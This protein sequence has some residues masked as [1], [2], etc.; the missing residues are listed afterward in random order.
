MILAVV[1]LTDLLYSQ[2]KSVGSL[3]VKYVYLT[4]CLILMFGLFYF[5]NATILQPPG[6]HY[7]STYG[8]PNLEYDVFYLSGTTYFTIGY[9]DI[10]PLGIY[11]RTSVV[12][13]ALCGCIINLVVL[14]KAFQNM[15]KH[16]G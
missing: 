7:T 5:I 11:A 6:L 4:T 2:Q 3:M 8:T 14:G 10:A 1:L 13:E 9:G 16:Q 12:M 15:A